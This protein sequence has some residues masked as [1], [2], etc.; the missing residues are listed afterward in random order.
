MLRC[1]SIWFCEFRWTYAQRYAYTHA[2]A[3][4]LTHERMHYALTQSRT[5][6]CTRA[7]NH[8][9]AHTT[10]HARTYA[11]KHGKLGM[12]KRLRLKV[13]RR[14]SRL[15]VSLYQKVEVIRIRI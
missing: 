13:E 3:H 8:A 5:Q 14:M 10:V 6:P 4:A 12:L 15:R 11:C 2:R 7:H 9:R 1:V